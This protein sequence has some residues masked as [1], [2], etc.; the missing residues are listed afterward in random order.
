MPT[1][2]R[3]FLMLTYGELEE[4]NLSAKQQ[5]K[6]RAAAHQLAEERLGYL[7]DEKRIKAVTVLFSDLEGRL[8]ML[9]YDKK[10]LLN[11]HDNLTFDGS[12]IRGFT[13]AARERLTFG[14][15][16]GAPFTG[17]PPTCS[18]PAKC[19]FS[20]TCST[21]DGIAVRRRHPRCAQE[22]SPTSVTSKTG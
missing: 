10:F 14:R 13:A 11:S 21:R 1:D 7:A 2:L 20:A 15:S 6:D 19:W 5:R 18:D 16:I 8:H 9:D 4:L 3:D 12:S 17:R 22:T